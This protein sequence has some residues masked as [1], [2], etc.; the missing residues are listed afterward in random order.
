MKSEKKTDDYPDLQI[1]AATI[2]IRRADGDNAVSVSMSV[3]SEEPVLTVAMFNDEWQ[4]VYE[5]LDH[6]D[7]SVDMSRCKDGLVVLDRHFGDQIGLISAPKIENRKL[8]GRVEF[9]SGSRAQELGRDAMNGLRRN[10]SVGY[11]VAPKS[12]RAEGVKDGIPVVRAMSWTP[13]EASFEPVP[14]DTT[15]GVNRAAEIGAAVKSASA[16]KKEIRKMNPKEIAQLFARAAK[17]GIDAAK[18]ESID[19]SDAASARAALDTMIV[20]KQ[21][22]DLAKERK[23]VIELKERKPPVPEAK[24]QSIIGGDV[25]TEEKVVR[26]YSVLNVLRRAAGLKV[27]CGFEDEINDECRRQGLG[28]KRGGQFVIPHAV[29]ANRA[30]TV[31][32]TSSATVG[33]VLDGSQYID[34]LRTKSILGPL[35]VQFM[36]GLT[37]NIAIPKMTAGAT[38]YWV[39]EAGAVTASAPTLGQVTGTPHTSGVLV[40]ISRLMLLQST[41]SAEDFVRNE[42]TERLARTL[43]LA[44]F[45]GTGNDGQPSAITAA[46]GINNPSVTQGAPTYAELLGF[47]GNIL[48]DSAE[49]DGQ[50]WAMTGEVWQKLAGTF[51]DGTAK[52][53]RVLDFQ[54]KTCLGFP[55]FVSEDVGAN[56]L[57][58]G[59][60]STVVVGVW[61]AGIDLNM[62]TATLSSSGGLRLVGLQDVDVMVRL[63]Q[64]LA[65]NA[66]VTN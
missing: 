33:T 29:L 46:S 22:A 41:P 44:V 49:A 1:R 37:G 11:V 23:T 31:S 45:G 12:Y 54:S 28:S 58:F 42:I 60:F 56:S 4:R 62:D 20:E 64:A 34:V 19:M 24:G 8:G 7:G 13:Y 5:V 43:Q 6:G 52:A 10:V 51:T 17:Y 35:G 59:D 18:I 38:G 66:A 61:G 40:D 65:Y 30:L 47:P 39:A 9:C 53:E 14:A 48:A 57:F 15:V 50:R 55:Y 26:K 16:Q 21:E 25:K 27:D 63:G 3:S 2:E 32:G 36:T